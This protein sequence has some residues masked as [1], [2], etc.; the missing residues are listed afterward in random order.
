MKILAIGGSGYVGGL[1]TP[2]L[3]TRHE[4]RI[5]DLKPPCDA[6]VE[7]V[8]GSV[9]A[10]NDVRGAM[11]GI[12]GLVYLAMGV[13]DKDGNHQDG[14]SFDANVKGVHLALSAAVTAGVRRAVYAST[15][16]V[17]NDWSKPAV[18]NEATPP[19]ASGVYGF[20]KRL[21]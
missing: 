6:D 16:S 8:Q 1:I 14:P 4:I 5:L 10:P 19:D 20:T 13:P 17:Y 3:K 9:L 2:Y 18:Q 15:M 12:E 21:G 7:Y 11:A